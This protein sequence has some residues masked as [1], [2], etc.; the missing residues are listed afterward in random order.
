M[1]D[2]ASEHTVSILLWPP[3]LITETSSRAPPKYPGVKP[4]VTLGD[5]GGIL[6]DRKEFAELVRETGRDRGG[7]SSSGFGAVLRLG[8]R[9]LL[10]DGE[11]F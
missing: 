6:K 3:S 7:L 1:A 11:H 10:G 5:I 9:L 4:R 2:K 8:E